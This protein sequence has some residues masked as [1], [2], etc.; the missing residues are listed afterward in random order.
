MRWAHKCLFTLVLVA[1]LAVGLVWLVSNLGDI[2][3]YG[4]THLFLR[5]AQT[6]EI[7]ATRGILYPRLLA[8]APGERSRL[9]IVQAGQLIACAVALVYFLNIFVG[10]YLRRIHTGPMGPR[11]TLGLLAALLFVDPVVGHYNLAIMTDGL[12]LSACLVFCAAFVALARGNKSAAAVLLPAH[13]IAAGLR[14]EKNVLLLGTALVGVAAYALWMR[15]RTASRPRRHLMMPVMLVC[16]GFVAS[17]LIRQVAVNVEPK[18]GA[19]TYILHGRIVFPNLE[20][21]YDDLPIQLQS[22]LT[23]DA[24]RRADHGVVAGR[25]L[26]S[27]VAGPD[28]EAYERLI[29]DLAR[30]VWR[31]RKWPLMADVVA[32]AA[33]NLVPPLVFYTR[34]TVGTLAGGDSRRGVYRRTLRLY[35]RLAE[36]H[37]RLSRLHV[38]LAGLLFVWAGVLA[39]PQAAL[40]VRKRSWQP[41]ADGK[42][43]GGVLAGFCVLNAIAFALVADLWLPRYTLFAHVLCVLLVLRGA[44]RRLGY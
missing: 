42:L 29:R 27:K 36:G 34:L 23:R 12:T 7:D 19:S 3:D 14:V 30:I 39:L 2:P 24:A 5:Q 41:A 15:G 43:A 33:G 28:P 17:L 13:M 25:K 40:A 8:A 32:D 35:E 20:A 21:V 22:K 6:Q 38:G 11:I 10:P 26:L 9:V 44:I 16:I 37:P 31:E 1:Y 18:W 4:D